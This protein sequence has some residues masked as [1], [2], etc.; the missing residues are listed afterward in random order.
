MV[1]ISSEVSTTS[2][3]DSDHVHSSTG[4]LHLKCIYIRPLI[5]FLGMIR[6][7]LPPQGRTSAKAKEETEPMKTERGYKTHC[8]QPRNE[9]RGEEVD[10]R[11]G[12]VK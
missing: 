1:W 7:K 12:G 8:A 4:V 5:N 3:T 6:K 2:A 9:C 10:G 11:G